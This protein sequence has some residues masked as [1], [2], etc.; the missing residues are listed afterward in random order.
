MKSFRIPMSEMELSAAAYEAAIRVDTLRKGE[1]FLDNYGSHVAT[2]RQEV[3][4]PACMVTG[5]NK[6]SDGT[7]PSNQISLTP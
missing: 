5:M 6:R 1:E 2:G 3:I 7:H 4:L